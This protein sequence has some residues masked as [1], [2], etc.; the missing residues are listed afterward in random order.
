MRVEVDLN[1]CCGHAQCNAHAPEV[2]DLDDDGYCSIANREV[3][4]ELWAKAR[5]GAEACP[6]QAIAIQE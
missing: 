2:Y 1:A 3:P 5:D 4:P 6:E